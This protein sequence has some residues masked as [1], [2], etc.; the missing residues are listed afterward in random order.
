MKRALFSTDYWYALATRR[1]T[2]HTQ[3]ELVR[4]MLQALRKEIPEMC[5]VTFERGCNLQCAHCIYPPSKSTEACSRRVLPELVKSAV[6]QLPS[7]NPLL[8]HEGRVIHPWHISVMAEAKRI[9]PDLKVGLIDNGSYTQHLDAFRQENLTLDWLDISVDGDE[10]A[11]NK[12]RRSPK[13]YK[14]AMRGLEVAREVTNGRV[15]SL[16]TIT[17]LNHDR[18]EAAA[19]A[20]FGRGLIDELHVSTITPAKPH[21]EALEQP[22][23]SA[24]WKQTQ[25]IYRRYGQT[26]GKQRIFFRL[27]R[28][29]ELAK[30][31]AVTSRREMKEAFKGASVAP[32]EVH[33]T[34]RDIPFIYAPLSIWPGET[35]LIDADGA[36]RTA[37]SIGEKL[38]DLQRGYYGNGRDL[39][40]FTVEQLKP[41]FDL[42]KA[43]RKCVDQWWQFAGSRFLEEELQIFKQF[44]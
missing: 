8:L 33:F 20:L 32:G 12:Q 27:Y 24:F 22:N 36:Y 18:L 4:L 35:F 16:F 25:T 23:L 42:R 9:R 34:L 29:Q 15:T 13:A 2:G 11:H 28:H 39:R 7:N 44:K 31:A 30:L 17:K 14:Q 21:L 38:S 37:H 1:K 3:T 43:Y 5:S 19:D 41:Y 10:E 40:G 26:D 6:K